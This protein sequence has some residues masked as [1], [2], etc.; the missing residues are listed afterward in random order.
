[1]ARRVE[2][3]KRSAIIKLSW[4]DAHEQK[5]DQKSSGRAGHKKVY[6]EASVSSR[7]GGFA[8]PRD[9]QCE[10]SPGQGCMARTVL[11]VAEERS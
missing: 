5:G 11:S 1:V 3:Y 6:R 8:A 7:Q 9:W 2:R 4:S 10:D